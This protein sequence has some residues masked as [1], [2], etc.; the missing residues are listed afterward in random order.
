MTPR[1]MFVIPFVVMLLIA[2][3]FNTPFFNPAQATNQE[4]KQAGSAT[5][6]NAI[7]AA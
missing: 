3:L 5:A 2:T 7:L 6:A 4:L 1:C